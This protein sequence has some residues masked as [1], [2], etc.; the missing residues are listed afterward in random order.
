MSIYH[1]RLCFGLLGS[2]LLVPGCSD[3]S[4]S[5][6]SGNSDV[7]VPVSCGEH[8]V[9]SGDDCVCDSAENYYGTAG[10][11]ELCTGE[12]KVLKKNACVC[13]DGFEDDGT[14]GCK[15]RII[16]KCGEHEIEDEDACI[17]DD[18]AGYYGTAGNCLPCL[19]D[20]MH[21]VGDLC[22]CDDGFEGNEIDGCVP[23]ASRI[24]AYNQ[25]LVDNYCLCNGDLNYYG[26]PGNCSLCVGT[27]RVVKDNDCVCDTENGWEKTSRGCQCAENGMVDMEGR[28]VSAELCTSPMF[29]VDG[30]ENRCICSMS[31][32]LFNNDCVHVGDIVSFGRYYNGT[33]L[34][35]QILEDDKSK[36]QLLLLSTEIINAEPYHIVSATNAVANA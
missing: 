19:G 25:K 16:S 20:H 23:K 5:G 17:C 27:G 26:S 15:E 6:N 33:A 35:W 30:V 18:E 22:I 7:V 21:I 10:N 9:V 2:V 8:E 4:N 36:G 24:C 11:C 14:G 34:K 1:K 28:C 3:D 31:A 13:A 32:V 12:H 29:L